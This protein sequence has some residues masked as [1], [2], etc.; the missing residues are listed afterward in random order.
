M[1]DRSAYVNRGGIRRPGETRYELIAVD[2]KV[3]SR[4][5]RSGYNVA[6]GIIEAAEMVEHCW[7]LVG[8]GRDL[9]RVGLEASM[10][11]HGHVAREPVSRGGTAEPGE[12][13]AEQDEAG[14]RQ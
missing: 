13:R 7:L 2:D 10:I 12:N 4:R 6:R 14:E 5:G 1:N 3:R 8:A 9:A 11:E